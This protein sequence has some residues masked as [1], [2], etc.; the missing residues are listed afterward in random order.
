MPPDVR[1]NVPAE[2]TGST[3]SERKDDL[4]LKHLQIPHI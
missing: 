4:A 2:N 3:D 1:E